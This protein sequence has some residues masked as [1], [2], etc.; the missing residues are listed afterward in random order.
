MEVVVSV[1][2]LSIVAA[3]V[4][5]FVAT[6]LN[7]IV[8]TE[9]TS[10]AATIAQEQL[11]RLISVPIK[12]WGYEADGET[13]KRV[14]D[15]RITW[16]DGLTYNVRRE[17]TGEA[18]DL[19]I[20]DSCPA[21]VGSLTSRK[22][23]VKLKITVTT[24]TARNQDSYST[25]TYITRDGNA[26]F[27]KSSITVKFEIVS[28]AGRRPYSEGSDGPAIEV[29]VLDK[30]LGS[31][32][33]T[34]IK[35]H[36]GLTKTGCITF[37]GLNGKSPEISF[38][39]VDNRLTSTG[40]TSYKGKINLISGGH[41]EIIFDIAGA[42]GIRVVPEIV[43][44]TAD[45]NPFGNQCANPVLKRIY[46]PI[47]APRHRVRKSL[48]EIAMFSNN[49]LARLE[50]IPQRR[51]SRLEQQRI[52]SAKK[53]QYYLECDL[54]SGSKKTKRWFLL[55]DTI[56]ISL[57]EGNKVTPVAT[58]ADSTFNPVPGQPGVESG[59]WPIVT[60]D[61]PKR[62]T[63]DKYLMVG[64]CVMNQS[65]TYAPPVRITQTMLN[66]STS[67]H[68]KTVS[69]KLWP[70]PLE[71]WYK[72]TDPE[73]RTDP[74]YPLVI[75]GLNDTRQTRNMFGGSR[76]EPLNKAW[77]SGCK[78]TPAFNVGWL[79]EVD[80]DYNYMQMSLA[81]PYGLYTY[82]LVP[83]SE[84]VTEEQQSRLRNT[85]INQKRNDRYADDRTCI[86]AGA[87]RLT[88]YQ[89]DVRA[90]YRPPAWD[91]IPNRRTD[92]EEYWGATDGR[93]KSQRRSDQEHHLI[94]LKWYWDWLD[95]RRKGS[96]L[97]RGPILD[98]CEANRNFSYCGHPY[99]DREDDHYYDD[100]ED[101]TQATYERPHS[102]QDGYTYD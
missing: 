22:D 84:T 61:N 33:R 91:Y 85:C 15:E 45:T 17:L 70:I 78:N 7:V 18:S 38:D 53:Y 86:P 37:L 16:S 82:S 55:A 80:T 26:T 98:A 81:L 89:T 39:L 12:K 47:A 32:T 24:N 64:S 30:Y 79:Q 31:D 29:N 49:E 102:I 73:G 63:G 60:L 27:L 3:A 68:P 42:G 6:S 34:K 35:N 44:S 100:Q 96:Y 52:D 40:E 46:T 101:E 14:V 43:G 1:V 62:W 72:P 21:V 74:Y 10:N 41:R 67:N 83:P 66:E 19:S 65:N 9:S 13:L 90:G 48:S 51:R 2:I 36:T 25:V 50:A 95:A 57:V 76:M 97:P 5:S 56:P 77:Y 8:R 87:P 71:G 23:L 75:K 94:Y 93:P 28:T 4:A 54:S 69:V 20:K 99:L 88:I 59:D 58:W 11:D 92:T